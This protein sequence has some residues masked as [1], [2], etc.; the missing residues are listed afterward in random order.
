MAEYGFFLGLYHSPRPSLSLIFIGDFHW[1][2]AIFFHNRSNWVNC[3]ESKWS[4]QWSTPYYSCIKISF[5]EILP[6]KLK[7]SWVV[8]RER[9]LRHGSYKTIALHSDYPSPLITFNFPLHW[10]TLGVFFVCRGK[11]CSEKWVFY[12]FLF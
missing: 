10:R 2:Q 4:Y 11:I 12:L 9:F 3:P 1:I 7:K 6:K 5:F 8:G